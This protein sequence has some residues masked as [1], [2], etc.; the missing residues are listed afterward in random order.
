MKIEGKRCG[1]EAELDEA[2]KREKRKRTKTSR[3]DVSSLSRRRVRILLRVLC[4]DARRQ[5]LVEAELARAREARVRG[6][7][8]SVEGDNGAVLDLIEADALAEGHA[9]SDGGD[10]GDREE[11]KGEEE[12][13]GAGK[14]GDGVDA[15]GRAAEGSPVVLLCRTDGL[16]VL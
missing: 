14:D 12:E 5:L 11:E 10:R 6:Y 13:E 8:R 4:A 7:G 16:E 2:R 1:R 9:G 15:H 3:L